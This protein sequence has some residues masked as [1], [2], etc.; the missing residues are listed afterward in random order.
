MNM[1]TKIANTAI[2]AVALAPLSPAILL[3]WLVQR[4]TQPQEARRQSA[5]RPASRPIWNTDTISY[6]V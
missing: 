1:L 4:A 5:R 6:A 2:T 3:M